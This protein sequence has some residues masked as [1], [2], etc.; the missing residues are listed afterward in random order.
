MV[1]SVCFV[2]LRWKALMSN[3][4]KT[5][6]NRTAITHFPILE[7]VIDE[8]FQQNASKFAIFYIY[9]SPKLLFPSLMNALVYV[10]I[11]QGIHLEKT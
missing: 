7:F 10:D 3:F 2:V 4:I 9:E 1:L 8:K 5:K 6:R 11:D